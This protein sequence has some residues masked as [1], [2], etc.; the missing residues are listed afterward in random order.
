MTAQGSA[1]TSNR[2]KDYC[3]FKQIV[4]VKIAVAT[5]RANRYIERYNRAIYNSLLATIVDENRW[6]EYVEQVQIAVNNVEC[7]TTGKTPGELVHAYKPEGGLDQCLIR[8]AATV[9]NVMSDLFLK[10][11]KSAERIKAEHVKQKQYYDKTKKEA[12]N[13]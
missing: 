10:R 13:T 6:E 7:R 12:K 2:F 5:S 3:R 1:F 8:E 11:A 4:H 9:P